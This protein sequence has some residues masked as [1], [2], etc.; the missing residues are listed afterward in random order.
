MYG[1]KTV[2]FL[3]VL[4]K[5]QLEMEFDYLF[6]FLKFYLKQIYLPFVKGLSMSK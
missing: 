4:D 1:T 3:L 2:N 6:F 5:R